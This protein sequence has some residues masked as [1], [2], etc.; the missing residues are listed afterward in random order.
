MLTG[1]TKY[2]AVDKIDK[3]VTCVAKLSSVRGNHIQHWLYVSRRTCDD[4]QDLAR[5]RLLF[6]GLLEFLEQPNVLY[7]DDALVCKGFKQF[8]LRR[9]ERAHLGAPCDQDSNEF[10]LQA[11]RNEQEGALRTR[12]YQWDI[13]LGANVWNVKSYMLPHPANGWRISTD[14]DTS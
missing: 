6:E 5:R 13:V 2:I 3:C 10:R 12:S 7:C 1:K 8:D 9:S 14:L 11:K 4:A